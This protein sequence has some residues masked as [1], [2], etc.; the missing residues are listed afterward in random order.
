MRLSTCNILATIVTVTPIAVNAEQDV[1]KYQIPTVVK[2]IAE[3]AEQGAAT[4]TAKQE[5][6]NFSLGLANSKLNLLED[7]ILSETG[8]T[9]LELSLGSDVFGLDSGTKTK[10]EVMAVY[11][12]HET[13]NLFL[14]NQTSIVNFDSRRTFNI[15][16]G[17]RHITDDET[18]ILGA[19]AFYD[20]ETKS[21]H[22]RSSLGFELL[23]AMLEFRANTYNAISGTIAYNGINETA[24]DGRDMKLTANLPYLY[25]SNVYYSSGKWKDGLGYE[26]K[27]KEFGITAEVLPN[28]FV[29]VAQQK[30]DSTKATTVASISYSIPLGNAA[31]TKR[32]MQ[33]GNWDSRMKPIREKLYK[34]VQRENRIMKKAIKLGVTVSG[35]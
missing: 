21:G 20:Y 15:G 17:A 29:T 5:F 4:E 34:P 19:N 30:K 22:K 24:L 8:F 10:S 26:T 3:G 1:L 33:D 9:H 23:T 11:G 28:L 27:T 31:K 6:H 13:S 25:S 32:V 14:F 12:L 7:K 16:L 2:N 35:Y 18:L